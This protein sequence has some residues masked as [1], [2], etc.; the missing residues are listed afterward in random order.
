[1]NNVNLSLKSG[2]G[3]GLYLSFARINHSCIC[4][5]RALKFLDGHRME[6]RAATKIAAGEEITTQYVKPSGTTG[7]RRANLFRKWHFECRWAKCVIKC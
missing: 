6:L 4:N 7:S 5:T 3:T 1:M 2:R